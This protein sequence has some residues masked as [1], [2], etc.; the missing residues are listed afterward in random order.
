[1]RNLYPVNVVPRVLHSPLLD[2][3][4]EHIQSLVGGIKI[5]LVRRVL[6][7][8]AVLAS[9]IRKMVQGCRKRVV[10]DPLFL[11]SHALVTAA[12]VCAGVVCYPIVDIAEKIFGDRF[13]IEDSLDPRLEIVVGE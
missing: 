11:N 5:L 10:H 2:R 12:G 3:I 4:G 1:M 7:L 13:A 6:L 9:Q 8:F